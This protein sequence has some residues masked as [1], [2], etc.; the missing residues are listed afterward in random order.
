VR[1]YILIALLLFTCCQAGAQYC[2][3][4]FGDS[5]AARLPRSLP[6]ESRIYTL[7]S[8]IDFQS[9]PQNIEKNDVI[10]RIDE[11]DSLNRLQHVLDITPYLLMKKGFLA[12]RKH[13]DDAALSILRDAI[14]AFDKEKRI[15][16]QYALLGHIRIFY[17]DLN[18]HEER[19][20]YYDQK[21]KYYQEHGP[22]ENTAACYHGFGGYYLYKGDYNLAISNYLKGAEVYKTFSPYSY[23]NALAII[24][25]TYSQWG[26]R[27]KAVE[28]LERSYP[29]AI[30]AYAYGDAV[31]IERELDRIYKAE[32]R[33]DKAL[34]HALKALKITTNYPEPSTRASVLADIGGIYVQMGKMD[35]ALSYLTAAEKLNNDSAHYRVDG[36]NGPMELGYYWYQYY[37]KA[38]DTA[39]AESSLLATYEDARSFKTQQLTLKYLKELALFYKLRGDAVKASDYAGRFINLN[40]SITTIQNTYKVAQYEH[41]METAVRDKTIK[42]QRN[43]NYG[44]VVAAVALLLASIFIFRSYRKQRRQ[45]EELAIAKEKA[46]RSERFKQQFL[47][48]MSH[49]IR[50]PMNAVIG[51]TE[52]L[53]DKQPR[54]DQEQYLDGIR[55]SSNTLLHIINDI[56]DLSKIEAGKVELEQIPFSPADIA[57][58]VQQLLQLKADEKGIAMIVSKDA[59]LPAVVIG[60]PT[61]LEQ[62]LLNLAGNAIKFTSQGS[63]MIGLKNEAVDN[64][65]ATIRFEVTDTGIG[66]PKDKIDAIFESFTQ[67]NISDTRRHGGTGLGLSISKH[68][69]EMHSGKLELTSEEGAGSCFSFSIRYAVSSE[70]ALQQLNASEH[71]DAAS[72]LSGL[73]ILLADDNEYNRI[74]AVDTL[75]N[76]ADLVIDS[77]TNGREAIALLLKNDYDLILMDVQMPEMDGYEATR[78][79]RENFTGSK[80]AIPI[81]ALTASV[82][83]SDLD[84]CRQA[85]M[86]DY[87]SKPFK[88]SD[89][90]R[91]IAKAANRE[92]VQATVKDVPAMAKAINNGAHVTDLAFLYN[93]CE[94]DAAQ[95]AK[96]K[97]LFTSTSKDFI[98]NIE[99]AVKAKDTVQLHKFVHALKPRMQMMG[100]KKSVALANTLEALALEGRAHEQMGNYSSQLVHDVSRAIE[101]LKEG[102]VEV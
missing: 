48:N 95:I 56:L 59:A 94:G 41:E 3:D 27:K 90:V 35:E 101:E 11:L 91:S 66:I 12:W 73:R 83:R 43:F 44:V 32:G 31:V 6:L 77:A 34:F 96:Y 79:I 23:A 19:K 61:R 63:V 2:Y 33:S 102:K 40:D 76:K 86:N 37:L 52:L 9:E 74:V 84:K 30:K 22:I 58:Q 51:M 29:L 7:A 93:F 92:V 46:E 87:V 25:Q 14:D 55:K 21:L 82:L 18:M 47:A 54:K 62:V 65:Y 50:T 10:N 42:S 39:R 53:I 81:I 38:G 99:A 24:G 78:Y 15:M 20:A 1:K 72:V 26:N 8:L 68:L 60:D 75:K 17:N 80:A 16:G 67:A 71:V 85:G 5:L 89:L 69:I 49:E 64:E 100:M 45:S 98:I 36:A 97:N 13:K 28:Y 4:C 57:A 70:E 88:L